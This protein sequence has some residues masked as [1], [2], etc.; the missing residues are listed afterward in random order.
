[1]Q[2][3]TGVRNLAKSRLGGVNLV[4]C[5]A[6]KNHAP[7][8]T[9]WQERHGG[10]YRS[11]FLRIAWGKASLNQIG[12]EPSNVDAASTQA[13]T[14]TF[15][16]TNRLHE[17]LHGPRDRPSEPRCLLWPTALT[18]SRLGRVLASFDSQ[19][20]T[21]VTLQS[22]CTHSSRRERPRSITAHGVHFLSLSNQTR[23]PRTIATN[24]EPSAP[25]ELIPSRNA[26]IRRTYNASVHSL[27]PERRFSRSRSV[28]SLFHASLP[29]TRRPK[30]E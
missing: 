16:H 28:G 9:C 3:S 29:G 27:R 20:A 6:R 5:L 18:D 13:A 17:C 4:Y 15:R 2:P 1:M 19:A 22:P 8:L 11:D 25:P 10:S 21:T 24:S 30:H 23:N 14:L 12:A 7:L 26:S